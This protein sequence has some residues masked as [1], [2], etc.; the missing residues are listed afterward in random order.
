MLTEKYATDVEKILAKYPPE[1]RRAA[2]MPLLHLIQQHQTYIDRNSM[3]EVAQLLGI[4]TTE[5]ASV[6]GFYSLY[7]DKPGGRFRIQVCTDLPCALRGADQFLENL[8]Q[9]L[10]VKPEETTSDG[11]FTIEPVMCLAACDRAPM[12]QIQSG[13][14]IDY[15]E[16]MTVDNTLALIN[17]LRAQVAR[18]PQPRRRDDH[19]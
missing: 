14:G 13:D 11:A 15:F 9:R 3:G 8:C 10:G 5:V 7:Y 19:D 1:E 16:N 2:V 17:Q 6:V 12:L 18:T 4:S